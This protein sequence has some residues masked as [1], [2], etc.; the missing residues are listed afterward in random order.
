MTT[1][2][3]TAIVVSLLLFTWAFL[4]Y[5]LILATE[6][7]R[8]EIMKRSEQLLVSS[9]LTPDTEQDVKIARMISFSPEVMRRVAFR[10]PFVAFKKLLID[11]T[12]PTDHSVQI[13]DSE[14]R[15]EF[16]LVRSCA[17]I[18]A[19][20]LSPFFAF[21]AMAEFMVIVI[22]ISAI[23]SFQPFYAVLEGAA[24]VAN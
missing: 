7:L 15:K 23:L 24:N 1:V 2:A 11:R 22:P 8:V 10:L 18:S 5:R 19:M 12:L 17:V 16:V 20:T 6:N 4:R 3:W 13:R 21:I 14:A 9:H